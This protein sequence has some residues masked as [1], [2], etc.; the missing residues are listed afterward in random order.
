MTFMPYIHFDGTCAEAM[1]FYA[2]VF[3]AKDLQL[4]RYS[5]VPE[6]AMPPVD[7]DRIMH[8]QLTAGGTPLM[9][10]DF[11][12]GRGQPQQAFSVMVAP[13]TVGEAQIV[14]DRLLAGGA[15]LMPFG[16]TFWS[17]GFGMV[18]DRFGTQWIIGAQPE[19]GA[20]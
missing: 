13:A 10:S 18:K 11:P 4:M 7:S 19:G 3:G 6:G 16:P 9:A 20:A 17:P 15:G 8:A 5:E 12:P 1:A 2:E 14:Y